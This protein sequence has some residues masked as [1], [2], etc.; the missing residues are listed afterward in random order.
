M[1]RSASCS[2]LS[3]C[4][5]QVEALTKVD[6]SSHSQTLYTQICSG[7]RK[8]YTRSSYRS[9]TCQTT[10]LVLFP[11]RI[12]SKGKPGKVTAR[13]TNDAYVHISAQ[14]TS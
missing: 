4:G 14:R 13:T 1:H 9:V 6:A 11:V 12:F 10:Q 2:P 8:R 3:Q 5:V 7:R